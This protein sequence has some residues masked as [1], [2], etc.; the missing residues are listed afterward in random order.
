[1]T[2]KI[3]IIRYGKFVHAIKRTIMNKKRDEKLAS[4]QN[5]IQKK[6]IKGNK[7]QLL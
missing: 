4:C 1:M 7:H 3:I 2:I 5:D 6:K